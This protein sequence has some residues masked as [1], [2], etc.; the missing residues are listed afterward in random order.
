[1]AYVWGA[2]QKVTEARVRGVIAGAVAEGVGEGWLLGSGTGTNHTGLGL[3]R[4]RVA[5][6]A[7]YDALTEQTAR[8]HLREGG[9][10]RPGRHRAR[11]HRVLRR[12]R[13][14]RLGRHRRQRDLPGPDV[15][16][17]GGRDDLHRQVAGRS[18][19]VWQTAVPSQI[20]F[21]GPFFGQSRLRAS[22]G[23]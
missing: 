8:R 13:R 2:G 23:R 5:A 10:L 17:R 22:A 7:S 14:A 20:N 21:E 15:E 11:R 18:G 4:I 6:A 1:M 16:R 12:G 9:E 3:Y 19:I